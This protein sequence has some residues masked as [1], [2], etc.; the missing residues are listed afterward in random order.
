MQ[1]LIV[2]RGASLTVLLGKQ[3]PFWLRRGASAASAAF[4]HALPDAV[5][6]VGAEL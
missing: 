4:R 1:L 6:R 2:N 5:P 3:S